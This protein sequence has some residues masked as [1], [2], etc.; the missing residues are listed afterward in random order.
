MDGE[1]TFKQIFMANCYAVT[2][3]ILLVPP[4]VALSNIMVAE[5]GAFF[6]TII[7][8]AYFWVALLFICANKQ[9]HDYSMGKSL[10]VLFISLL[11]MTVLVLLTLLFLIL[12]QQFCGFCIDFAGDLFDKFF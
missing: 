3:L 6:R 5:E 11:V 12:M 10:A 8:L 2:P 4:A 9:I 1:A 7:I